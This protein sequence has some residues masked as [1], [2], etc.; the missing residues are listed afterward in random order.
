MLLEQAREYVESL[1]ESELVDLWNEY[2]NECYMYDDIIYVNDEY[3]LDDNFTSPSDAVRACLYGDY[4]YTDPWVVFDGYG[5]LQSYYD[6]CK[7][8]DLDSLIEWY[9]E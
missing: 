5:N 4:T 9:A 3:F 7:A 6:A 8:I 1:A 2:C